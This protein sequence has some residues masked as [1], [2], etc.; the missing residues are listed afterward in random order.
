[1]FDLQLAMQREFAPLEQILGHQDMLLR[2]HVAYLSTRSPYYRQLFDR[3]GIDPATIHS[4]SD[5]RNLPFT[6]KGNI[7]KNPD[8]F[9]CVDQSEFVDL[10]LTSG[11]LGVPI[12][13]PQTAADLERLAVNEALAF[14]RMGLGDNDRVLVAVALERCFMAGLAYFL[15]LN[16]ISATA[17]RGG[18]SSIAH[19]TDLVKGQRPTAIIGVPS[20]LRSLAEQLT[21]K[22]FDPSSAGVAKILCIGEPVR[23]QNFELSSIGERLR[24]LW[25]AE[26]FGTYA[27]T[28]VATAFTDCPAGAGGHLI[29]DLIIVEIVDENGQPQPVGVP[30]EIVVTPLRV[31]GMPMLR[32]RTGDIAALHDAPCVCGRTTPRLGPVLGRLAQRLKVRGTTV[33]PSAVFNALQGFPEITGYY[34]EVF[35]DFELSNRLRVTIACTDDS[36]TGNRVAEQLSAQLRVRP[37]V[38]VMPLEELQ[39]RT[40]QE[41]R[42]K[43]LNFFDYRQTQTFHGEKLDKDN[44]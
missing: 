14:L 8:A 22:R 6:T 34:L 25:Q 27:S 10:C 9:F 5:L 33:Y 16:R 36:L 44:A 42:R 3:H 11:T 13:V 1:M 37:E 28:E 30:G 43:P 26:I 31:T 7:E 38:V 19:L 4:L 32:Y 40:H 41:G 20:L 24:E 15:G 17:I 35:D 23:S 18:A 39:L 12:A 21:S 2:E 29:P